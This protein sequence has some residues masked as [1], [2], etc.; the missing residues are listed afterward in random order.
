MLIIKK[1][2]KKLRVDHFLKHIFI[3]PGVVLGIILDENSIISPNKV[4]IGFFSSFLIASSNYVLNDFCD[5]DFDRYHPLK[6]N[7]VKIDNQIS[8]KITLITYFATLSLG[9]L[10]ANLINFYFFLTSLLFFFSGVLYN[11]KPFRLKNIAYVDVITESI[12]NPIRLYLGWFLVSTS[13]ELLP[14]FSFVFFYWFSGGFLMAAKR[15]AEVRYFI[16]FSSQNKLKKYRIIYKDYTENSLIIYCVIFLLL[17]SFNL[18]TFLI[19]Y[20]TELILV[21]PAV[22]A[23]FSYYLH[24]TLNQNDVSIFPEKLYKNKNIIFLVIINIFL[25]IILAF[26]DIPLIEWIV[27]KTIFIK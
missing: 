18:T 9:L 6:E 7:R 16:K 11:V 3:L 19:K 13:H 20:K 21:Y 27:K 15:L 2:I 8:K 10:L 1:I 23:L 17:S 14:P 4:L 24:L 12:N 25:F 22:V 5:K 26:A